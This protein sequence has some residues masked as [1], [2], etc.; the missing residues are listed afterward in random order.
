M[1]PG[2][3]Q[4]GKSAWLLIEIGMI[5]ILEHEIEVVGKG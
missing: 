3:G 5:N 1:D 4:P 2:N